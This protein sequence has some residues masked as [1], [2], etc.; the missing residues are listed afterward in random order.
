MVAQPRALHSRWLPQ[1]KVLPLHAF[2][3]AINEL[4][5]IML[6][7]MGE[8]QCIA[9]QLLNCIPPTGCIENAR[10]V[11]VMLDKL[12]GTANAGYLLCCWWQH[13]TNARDTSLQPR[14]MGQIKA[15]QLGGDVHVWGKHAINEEID[16][17]K[18]VQRCHSIAQN[19]WVRQKLPM[20]NSH[21]T[22]G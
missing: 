19:P 11:V 17:P 16:P 15:P 20:G 5:G 1:Q 2:K 8:A 3:E 14:W 7:P 13:C 10:V 9:C 4:C 18:Q 22:G 6:P 21:H 12:E